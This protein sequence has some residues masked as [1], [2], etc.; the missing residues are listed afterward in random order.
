MDQLEHSYLYIIHKVIM[1]ITLA[2]LIVIQ[3]F[4]REIQNLSMTSLAGTK[5]KKL[6]N[7]P[8]TTNRVA[9]IFKRILLRIRFI[10][11]PFPIIISIIVMLFEY[12]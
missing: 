6:V 9:H 12:I 2:I 3:Y 11:L 5:L 10:P 1:H 7:V 8:Y 4:Q